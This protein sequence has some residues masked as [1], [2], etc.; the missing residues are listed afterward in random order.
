MK[1]PPVLLLAAGLTLV[2]CGKKEAAAPAKKTTNDSF[3]SGNP[4][5]APVDYLGA[6]GKGKKAAE[7]VVDTSTLNRAVQEF[8]AGEGR[9][10][11]DLQELV[12]EKYMPK[13]PQAPYG[14]KIVYNPTT[15][16]V[17]V[18]RTQ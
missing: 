2:G 14:M 8:Y 16:Q 11:K 18:V 17:S 15:G 5:T 3:S 4:I 9:Y 10:P 6:L 7:R 12:T 1:L 13:L